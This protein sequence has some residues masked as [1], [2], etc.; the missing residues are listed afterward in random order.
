MKNYAN[1]PVGF[2]NDAASVIID[3]MTVV[4]GSG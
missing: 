3:E 1:L 4:S 2:F